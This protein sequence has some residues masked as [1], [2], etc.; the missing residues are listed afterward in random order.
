MVNTSKLLGGLWEIRGPR[1]LQTVEQ[2]DFCWTTTGWPLSLV[3]T[4]YRIVRHHVMDQAAHHTALSQCVNGPLIS[5]CL[6]IK[7][8]SKGSLW[9]NSP[10]DYIKSLVFV[11]LLSIFAQTPAHVHTYRCTSAHTPIRVCVCTH[12]LH[13]SIST[14]EWQNQKL[15]FMRLD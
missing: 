9:Q 12:L 10:C 11:I 15:Y 8:A 14:G 1:Q 13:T 2:I 4:A 3:W 6:S 7:L 5:L